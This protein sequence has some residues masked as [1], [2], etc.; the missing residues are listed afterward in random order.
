M[1][2]VFVLVILFA[3]N[4]ILLDFLC[5]SLSLFIYYYKPLVVIIY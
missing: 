5:L 2:L 4:F 1:S 3:G